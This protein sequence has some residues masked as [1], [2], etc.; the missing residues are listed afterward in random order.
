MIRRPPRSTPLYSS[1]ASD[2]YK[3]QV[4]TQSTWDTRVAMSKLNM[5][6]LREA[7][8]NVYAERKER[9]FLETVELQVMLKDYDPQKDKRFA[10]SVRLPHVPRPKLKI[11]VIGDAAHLEEAKKIEGI[12]TKDLEGLRAFN[13]VK[14]DI[15]KWAKKYHV[16]LCTDSIVRQLTKVLGPILNKIN[17]FPIAIT[18]NESL[19]KKIDEVKSSVRFQ[20]KKVLCMG[21][22]VGNL[23]LSEEQVRQNVT[24]S[25]NFLVSLLKKGWNNVKTCLLY[26]SPSPRD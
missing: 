2:V 6:F 1:A 8:H 13:R 14:K 20:L 23:E 10:G 21:T 18:H 22:A 7:I 4:S 17:R 19:A 11:C 16:L 5:D 25:L 12:E 26:T 3:R 24:M 9:K 15:K